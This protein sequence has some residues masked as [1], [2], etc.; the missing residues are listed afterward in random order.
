MVRVQLIC[1]QYTD[2]LKR[3]ATWPVGADTIK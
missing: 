2:Y 3:Y 1:K